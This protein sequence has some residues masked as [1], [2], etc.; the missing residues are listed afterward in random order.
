MSEL[1]I[2]ARD[3]VTPGEVLAT[4]M[5]YLPS[6]GTY[7]NEDNILSNR[8][9][10]VAIEGK[11]IKIIPLSGRYIPKRNDIIIGKVIDIMMSGW[12]VEM[13]SAY[14]SMLPL[15]DASFDFISKT[16][17]LTRYFDLDDWVVAKITNVTS[18][19]LVDISVKGP[20]LRKLKGGRI[21]HV[22]A[23]KVPRIIGKKGSM[24][25]MIK[26]ATDAQV[27]VGQ[28]GTVWLNGSPEAEKIVI[29]TIRFIEANAHESGLT[30]KVRV[31]LS[32]KTGKEV[33]L[34]R[35]EE[36]EQ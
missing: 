7:R 25:S 16:A 14:T 10:L 17:D 15:R 27:I 20:G 18:Q 4:G 30:E 34:G 9:G 24:V 11:V 6:F 2:K 35:E 3:I 8:L 28:N 26:N 36:G 19:N 1:K 22:Q 5:D 32:E 21:I 33:A 29:D 13:N 12:R 23:S 31:T